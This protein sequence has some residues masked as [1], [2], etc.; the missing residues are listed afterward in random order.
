[1]IA[2]GFKITGRVQGVGFRYRAREKAIELGV[3]GYVQNLPDGSVYCQV[4]G[5]PDRVRLMQDWLSQG[6]PF[7]A[8]DQV[9]EVTGFTDE[10]FEAFYI[11]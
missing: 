5:E 9:L 1:M 3:T 6:P 10:Q 2:K 4:R 7:A 11:R 8:V